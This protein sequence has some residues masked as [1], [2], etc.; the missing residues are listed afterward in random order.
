MKGILNNIKRKVK[1]N[2]RIITK[3]ISLRTYFFLAIIGLII[4]LSLIFLPD[5]GPTGKVILNIDPTYK[6]GQIIEGTLEFSLTENELIPASTKVIVT[7]NDLSYE[8]LLSDLISDETVEGEFYIID[9]NLSGSG[10]GYSLGYDEI[11]PNVS[12]TLNIYS[13]TE[14]E[15]PEVGIPTE[16]PTETNEKIEPI[17]NETIPSEPSEEIAPVSKTETPAEEIEPVVPTTEEPS[18]IEKTDVLEVEIPTEEPIT[19]EESTQAPIT[20]SAIGRFFKTIT[21]QV[22]LELKTTIQGSVSVNNPVTY[23]LEK[24]QTT[25]IASSSQDVN[26]I[27]ENNT[28]KVTTDYLGETTK[29]LIIN[30]EELNIPAKE[31]TLTITLVYNGTELF[32]E[33]KIIRVEKQVEEIIDQTFNLTNYTI[34]KDLNCQE[35][36][37][38][39]LW[40]SGYSNKQ[41][42][43]T[44][45]I[46]WEINH[47]C[48]ETNLSNCMLNNIE[49]EARFLY[50]TPIETIV[51]GEGYVQISNP[52]ESICNNPEQGIYL[53]YL[54]FETLKEDEIKL[55]R[56]CDKN[57]NAKCRENIINTYSE[58]SCYGIKI[59]ASQYLIV[60]VF[61][62]KY[63]LCE[64]QK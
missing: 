3:K 8:S 30:L 61:E 22:S 53:D 1:K 51:E 62:I 13:E 57:P 29:D 24:G 64:G 43:S 60:D 42:G 36:T 27:I 40:S 45:Y 7:L 4:A 52:D 46:V 37:E 19:P 35:F 11:Y 55:D 56:Y 25:E 31:G 14:E 18:P 5:L 48:E 20:G 16:E 54:A 49:I 34:L 6:Q 38:Q 44:E 2:N 63:K 23:T 33:S 17:S 21:G 41:Q 26:L 59:Y 28:V 32:S 12:F 39:V 50:P 10:E 58:I 9:K 15:I 47:T